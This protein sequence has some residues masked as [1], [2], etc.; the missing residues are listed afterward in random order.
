MAFVI[1]NAPIPRFNGV[2]ALQESGVYMKTSG[3]KV[4]TIHEK[5]LDDGSRGWLISSGKHRAFMGA[6]DKWMFYSPQFLAWIEAKN[7]VGKR[8][9]ERP[10]SANNYMNARSNSGSEDEYAS[11]SIT[12]AAFPAGDYDLETSCSFP[13]NRSAPYSFS[14]SN[15]TPPHALAQA[16][17]HAQAV[18]AQAE[19]Q[20]RQQSKRRSLCSRFRS[21][22]SR[23]RFGGGAGECSRVMPYL[24]KDERDD[25]EICVAEHEA[26][27]GVFISTPQPDLLPVGGMEGGE[28]REGVEG[29][30]HDRAVPGERLGE[31]IGNSTL[32]NARLLRGNNE[33]Y[34]TWLHSV[35]VL[36]Q[37]KSI[38]EQRLLQAERK[39][40]HVESK[41]EFALADARS[42]K[43]CESRYGSSSRDLLS[44]TPSGSFV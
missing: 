18:A 25:V 16:R 15:S 1:E 33:V 32:Q 6:G 11:G 8:L 40:R 34:Q 7:M 5:H 36:F 19:Q 17:A 29:E 9:E 12:P 38:T 42:A 22:F 37:A 28:E 21:L 35:A 31:G 26:M 4:L 10:E 13:S 2:Y 14:N 23:I 43:R 3:K 30:G 24:A 41:L 44:R 39:L 27:P 20:E